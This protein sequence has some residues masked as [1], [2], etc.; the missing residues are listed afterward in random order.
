MAPFAAGIAELDVRLAVL[1]QFGGTAYT[2]LDCCLAF[3][4]QMFCLAETRFFFF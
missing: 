3:G 1:E 2:Q 4:C